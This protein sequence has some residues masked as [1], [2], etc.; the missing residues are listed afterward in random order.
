MTKGA[1]RLLLGLF[2]IGRLE[3]LQ[4]LYRHCQRLKF[5]PVIIAPADHPVSPNFATPLFITLTMGLSF[6]C[7]L[8]ASPRMGCHLAGAAGWRGRS[9]LL[10]LRVSVYAFRRLRGNLPFFGASA[11]REGAASCRPPMRNL[12]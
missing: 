7:R 4:K 6:S 10:M 5:V 3:T 9:P 12:P 2:N 8:A 11:R 1:L